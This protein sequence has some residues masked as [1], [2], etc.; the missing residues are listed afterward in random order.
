MTA[1]EKSKLIAGRTGTSLSGRSGSPS[2]SVSAGVSCGRPAST[3]I[4]ASREGG[5]DSSESGLAMLVLTGIFD[6]LNVVIRQTLMQYITPDAMR[7][8][9]SAVNYIFIGCSNELGALESG[10][11]AQW[12]GT[13]PA[14]V[15]GGAGAL[16]VVGVVARLS[17]ALRRLGRLSDVKAVEP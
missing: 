16:L 5:N 10:L 14:I 13:V 2:S 7:G 11:A 3:T 4:H 1:T 9:V 6:N 8:R 17:P 15:A 12:L